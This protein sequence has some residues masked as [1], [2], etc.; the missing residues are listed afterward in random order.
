MAAVATIEYYGIP[1]DRPML[2]ALRTNWDGLKDQLI[3]RI[4]RTYGVF[5]WRHI[6]AGSVRGMVGASPDSVDTTGVR[7]A[8]FVG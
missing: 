4:D 3:T 1:I 8:R 7:A 5:R 6:Q 2:D